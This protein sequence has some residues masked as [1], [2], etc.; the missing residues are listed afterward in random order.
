MESRTNDSNPDRH[1][2]EEQTTKCKLQRQLVDW[3]RYTDTLLVTE[4]RPH[5]F[6]VW[7]AGSRQPRN[8]L[9]RQKLHDHLYR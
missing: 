5:M 3:S 1:D 8:D 7:T 6:T 9:G 4:M 2:H